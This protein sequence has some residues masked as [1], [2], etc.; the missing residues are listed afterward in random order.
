MQNYTFEKREIQISNEQVTQ[1]GLSAITVDFSS[2]QNFT[3]H[4]HR[5]SYPS[6]LGLFSM[7]K[8]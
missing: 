8:S 2:N 5:K 6:E 7:I 1:L 4:K 3:N